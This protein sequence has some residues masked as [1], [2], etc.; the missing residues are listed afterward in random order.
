MRSGSPTNS[1][2]DCCSSGS[3]CD[4]YFASIFFRRFLCHMAAWEAEIRVPVFLGDSALCW[5][6]IRDISISDEENSLDGSFTEWS[7]GWDVGTWMMEENASHDEIASAKAT[8][9]FTAILRFLNSRIVWASE[10]WEAAMKQGSYSFFSARMLFHHALGVWCFLV[11]CVSS[12]S[13]F[14]TLPPLD[15]LRLKS[16]T[17]LAWCWLGVGFVERSSSR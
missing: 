4:E 14:C 3:I 11:F 9:D 10:C 12:F 6:L 16:L 2:C 13:A 5:I 1:P 7:T 8:I 15:L 17:L